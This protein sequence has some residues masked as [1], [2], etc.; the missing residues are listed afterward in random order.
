MK[1]S[2]PRTLENVRL[3][4]LTAASYYWY[5]AVGNDEQLVSALYR[6]QAEKLAR[7]LGVHTP[8][9][10]EVRAYAV[11]RFAKHQLHEE[12]L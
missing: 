12:A 4:Y 7:E 9:P 5:R 8:T 10:E 11:Q 2:T 3:E 1:Q 6:T